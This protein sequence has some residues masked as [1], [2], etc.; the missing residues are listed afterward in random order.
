MFLHTMCDVLRAVFFLSSN[1]FLVSVTCVARNSTA[2]VTSGLARITAELGYGSCQWA[3]MLPFSHGTASAQRLQV[4]YGSA[5]CLE[6][7]PLQPWSPSRPA[8][9]LCIVC[10]SSSV[11]SHNCPGL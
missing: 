5:T 3:H 10:F 4:P 9:T 1:M 8:N 6:H 7:A 2:A 11:V